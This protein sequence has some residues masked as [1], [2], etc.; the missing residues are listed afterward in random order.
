MS[1][2]T[3][4]ISTGI[5]PIHR[6][7]QAWYY[8]VRAFAYHQWT[9]IGWGT[10]TVIV[11]DK[12]D[13]AIWFQ[14][15]GKPLIGY[16]P[17][18]VQ[19]STTYQWSIDTVKRSLDN[20]NVNKSP[21]Q[22]W[23]YVFTNS[24]AYDIVARAY[25]WSDIVGISK[26]NVQVLSTGQLFTGSWPIGSHL[27]ANILVCS[28]GETIG[29]STIL[30]GFTTWDIQSIKRDF[31]DGVVV[32]N[33]LLSV[34]KNCSMVWPNIVV[35]TI[36]LKDGRTLENIL[37]TYVTSDQSNLG[38]WSAMRANPLVQ[39][40]YQTIDYTIS[41]DNIRFQDISSIR[42]EYGDQNQSI[43]LAWSIPKNLIFSHIYNKIGIYQTTCYITVKDGTILINQVT[44]QIVDT[45]NCISNNLKCD[46]DQDTIAD[47]CD[48]DIDGDGV[49]NILWLLVREN[50]P[51]CNI[52]DSIIDDSIYNQYTTMIWSGVDLDNCPFVINVDQIDTNMNAYGDLCDSSSS[53]S[54]SSTSSSSSSTSPSSSSSSSSTSSS[55]WVNDQDQDGLGDLIDSCPYLPESFNGSQ[56]QDG[57]PDLPVIES[58]LDPYVQTQ[59][60]RACPCPL[61]DFQADIKWWDMVRAL[62]SDPS[63]ITIYR[64]SLSKTIQELELQD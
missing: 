62:L 53:T 10:L 38:K 20:Q 3:K 51:S 23:T 32:S 11:G 54:S 25:H 12:T 40:V 34:V 44:V 24:G 29:F 18:I 17:L 5:A 4:M 56:D 15:I 28:L 35:Q 9:R 46:M 13:H 39:T 60:C 26:F 14:A 49:R 42:C 27:S 50:F 48:Q 21:K 41:T 33:T 58:P 19:L 22:K 43:H 63:G 59:I 55:S 7:L 30:S 64:Y 8:I 61:A 16:A 6:Y 37:N 36:T 52:I 2:R 45:Y 47:L 1:K 57:C 31:G